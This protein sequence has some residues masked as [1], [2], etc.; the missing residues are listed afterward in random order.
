MQADPR[1]NL[2]PFPLRE[3]MSDNEMTP[4]GQTGPLSW[5]DVYTA[6]QKS[7]ERIIGHIDDVVMPLSAAKDDHETRLRA[8]EQGITPWQIGLREAMAEHG[9]RIGSV[10]TNEE[11]NR[12]AIAGSRAREIGV[13]ATIKSGQAILLTIISVVSLVVAIFAAMQS[14]NVLVHVQ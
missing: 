8:L 14:S 12:S 7:E 3:P 1:L 6:V 11:T 10:E 4:T 5:R 2:E 9:R 13:F